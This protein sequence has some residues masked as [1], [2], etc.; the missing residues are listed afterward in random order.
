M[1]YFGHVSLA[2]RF[3]QS[4]AFYLG[5]MLPDFASII[6]YRTPHCADALVEKGVAFHHVSDRAFH[7]SSEFRELLRD[8]VAKLGSLGVRKGAARAAAHVGIELLLDATLASSP[9]HSEAFREALAI[10]S[11]K[12]LGKWLNWNHTNGPERFEALRLRLLE[13]TGENHNHS[14]QRI[15][16]RLT[17]ALTDRPRLQLTDSERAVVSEWLGSTAPHAAAG[18]SF[19]WPALVRRVSSHWSD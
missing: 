4:A 10:A 6:R 9:E 3:N 19:L 2:C 15:A 14:I 12:R 5:S 13:R 16:A 8:S 17:Y 18:W 11:P 1:N 7:D